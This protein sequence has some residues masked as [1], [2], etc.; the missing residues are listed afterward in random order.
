MKK[1]L[2]FEEFPRY[3]KDNWEYY[4]N[5]TNSILLENNFSKILDT[6]NMVKQIDVKHNKTNGICLLTCLFNSYGEIFK[7]KQEFEEILNTIKRYEYT[8]SVINYINGR[9]KPINFLRLKRYPNNC[10]NLLTT[11][12]NSINLK[13]PIPIGYSTFTGGHYINIIGYDDTN[14]FLYY[15]ENS[16][17]NVFIDN[18]INIY[19]ELLRK[20][21]FTLN[22]FKDFNMDTK[23]YYNI[24]DYNN[25]KLT[26]KIFFDLSIPLLYPI[27]KDMK[28]NTDS[29]HYSLLNYLFNFE[30]VYCDLKV[31]QNLENFSIIQ[32]NIGKYETLKDCIQRL[33]LVL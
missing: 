5:T 29:I 26:T 22:D 13:I 14:K 2:T 6:S 30:I 28:S 9:L 18:A 15:F 12:K 33:Q 19:I 3:L 16:S 1:Y 20:K 10:K 8:Q 25:G 23:L 32:Q 17:E 27:F 21:K 7:S 11:I 24:K 4:L 31:L